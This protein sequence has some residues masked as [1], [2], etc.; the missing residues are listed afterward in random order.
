MGIDLGHPDELDWMARGRD[1][2]IEPSRYSNRT[3]EA[4]LDADAREALVE[5]VCWRLVDRGVVPEPESKSDLDA[6]V[7][8]IRDDLAELGDDRLRRLERQVWDELEA[9]EPSSFVE[10]FYRR[11]ADRLVDETGLAARDVFAE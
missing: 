2:D 8:A 5:S 10:E 7:T 11:V 9:E 3:S 1:G 4:E 6:A